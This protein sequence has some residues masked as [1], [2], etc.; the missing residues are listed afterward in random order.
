MAEHL[1]FFGLAAEIFIAF[2]GKLIFCGKNGIFCKILRYL[3]HHL[4]DHRDK[5]C[6][7]TEI[8]YKLQRKI[9]EAGGCFILQPFE[10]ICGI[11]WP[12]EKSA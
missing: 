12:E 2:E 4:H 1:Y 11:T 7:K 6:Y 9:R 8:P 10:N 3:G 5:G